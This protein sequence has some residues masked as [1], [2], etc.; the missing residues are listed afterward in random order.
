MKNKKIPEGW[1]KLSEFERLTGMNNR[2]VVLAISRGKIPAKCVKKIG[3][4]ATSPKYINPQI[5]AMQWYKNLNSN[6][7]LSR[8]LRNNLEKYIKKFS[9]DIVNKKKDTKSAKGEE[10]ITFDEA[11]LRE[12]VAKAKVAELELSE[13]EGSLISKISVYNSLFEFGKQ[14]RDAL[15]SI[16]E[17]VTDD[18][19]ANVNNRTKVHNFMYDAIIAELEKF[20]EINKKYE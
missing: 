20:S 15:L 6:H 3:K 14:M 5:A 17:R 11:L 4:G 2:T 12:K 19:I 7:H 1:V 18:I 13:K 10:K 9:P 16:P 8:T